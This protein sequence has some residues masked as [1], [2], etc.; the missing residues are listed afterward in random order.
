MAVLSRTEGRKMSELRYSFC[1][2]FSVIEE[3]DDTSQSN[4]TQATCLT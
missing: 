4:I 2:A 1:G 3:T